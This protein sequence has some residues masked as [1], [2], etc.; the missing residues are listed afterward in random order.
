MYARRSDAEVISD[1]ETEDFCKDALFNFHACTE[2]EL[3]VTVDLVE[4]L[5]VNE[6][7]TRVERIKAGERFAAVKLEKSNSAE[8]DPE[9]S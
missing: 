6:E 9:C 3:G 8:K 5:V 2:V 1:V 4:F 7:I